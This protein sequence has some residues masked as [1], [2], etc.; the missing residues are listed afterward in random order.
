MAGEDEIDRRRFLQA[1]LATI[2]TTLLDSCSSSRK[3]QKQ[4]LDHAKVIDALRNFL[5]AQYDI[6]FFRYEKRLA[7]RPEENLP[8]ELEQRFAASKETLEKLLSSHHD[9]EARLNPTLVDA[10]SFV[11]RRTSVNAEDAK[12]QIS[13]LSDYFEQ[14]ARLVFRPVVSGGV[15]E[16]F[17]LVRLGRT[18]AHQVLLFGKKYEVPIRQVEEEVIPRMPMYFLKTQTSKKAVPILVSA[19]HFS[20]DLQI[21]E[22]RPEFYKAFAEHLY[23]QIIERKSAPGA[24]IPEERKL[25]HRIAGQLL[26]HFTRKHYDKSAARE[27]NIERIMEEVIECAKKHEAMHYIDNP[28]GADDFIKQMPPE[29]KQEYTWEWERHAEVRA[30]LATMCEGHGYLTLGLAV[31]T[32]GSGAKNK[33]MTW[34]PSFT[35]LKRFA[36]QLVID[37]DDYKG[38]VDVSSRKFEEI[39]RQL[40]NLS[41]KQIQEIARKILDRTYQ[42]KSLTEYVKPG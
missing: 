14:N 10:L 9:E 13:R 21:V 38:I 32:L 27:S 37:S 30:W 24:V 5:F 4:R 17:E 8:E 28:K 39:I 35:L 1:S 29:L 31:S 3:R 25:V 11:N 26:A 12:R 41:E 7:N 40:P 22:L 36:E 33:R 20:K 42:G 18:T 34:D 19:G 6:E 16:G 2:A 15:F 23:S